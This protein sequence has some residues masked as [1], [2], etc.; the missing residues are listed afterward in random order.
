MTKP[1][2]TNVSNYPDSVETR[3]A[4]LEMAISHI[5]ETLLRIENDIKESRKEAKFDFKFIITAFAGLAA[6][7]AHGFHWF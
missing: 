3:V 1:K 5:N 4:L 2:E 7:M 6:I